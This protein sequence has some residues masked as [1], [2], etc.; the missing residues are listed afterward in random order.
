[1]FKYLK[2]ENQDSHFENKFINKFIDLINL[3]F[4]TV[5]MAFAIFIQPF[6]EY[7]HVVFHFGL[8]LETYFL[9]SC[10]LRRIK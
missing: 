2:Y 10:N 7:S 4:V 3:Y 1:M 8:L 5:F 6:Y 9:A